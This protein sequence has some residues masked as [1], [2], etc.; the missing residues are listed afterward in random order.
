MK[1]LL[2]DSERKSLISNFS[3]LV[4]L[5]I[6]GYLF[7]LI[8][9]PYLAEVI[10]VSGF[11]KISFA[12]AVTLWVMTITNWGFLYTA[13]RDVARCRDDI[14]KVSDIYSDVLWSRL[15]VMVVCFAVILPFVL[16][17]PNLRAEALLLFFSLLS[18]P[19]HVLF[20]DWFFQAMEKMKY[21]TI[22]NFFIRLIFTLAIFVFIKEKDDYIL[23]PLFLSMGFFFSGVLAQFIVIRKWKVQLKGFSLGRVWN[24]LRKGLD[25]FVAEFMPN[26]YNSFSQLLLAR[27]SGFS[28]NGIYDA[29]NKFFFLS[30]QFF[31]LLSQTFFPV[32]SRNENGHRFYVRLSMP[33]SV[34]VALLLWIGAPYLIDWLYTDEFSEA[35]GVLRVLALSFPFLSLTNVYGTNRMVLSGM[36]TKYRQI[37]LWVSSFGF[38]SSF[39]VVYYFGFMGVAYLL[40]LVR[41]VMGMWI[42]FSA[43]SQ[44]KSK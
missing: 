33:L 19:G 31:G 43:R 18:V 21:I 11:G 40:L 5:K 10:G 3:W 23:Q 7:P 15:L 1:E 39:F 30:N 2:S 13:T 9:V 16:W 41:M 38:L 42:Y 25:I 29:G 14:E 36:E 4:V 20:P 17:I 35:V 22:F 37:V 6:A 34:L 24:S 12:S 26:L 8:T 44:R 28:A 27:F 32:L